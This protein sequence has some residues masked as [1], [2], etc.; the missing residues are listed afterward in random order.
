MTAQKIQKA[1]GLINRHHLLIVFPD[2]NRPQP[3]SLWS[4]LHPKIPMLW[5]WSDEG[6][7][8]VLQMWNL[9]KRLSEDRRVIYLKWYK[10]RATFISQ[11]LFTALLCLSKAHS[12]K[13]SASAK[14]ILS[15]LESDSPL[16]TREVKTLADLRGK[17]NEPEYHRAMKLLFQNFLIVGCGEVDDG[18]FPSLAVGATQNIYEELW[19][20]ASK[21]NVQKAW[22]LV[23]QVMP[24]G[25]DFRKFLDR[26]SEKF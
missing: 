7:D 12:S 20:A 17:D 11:D 5:E 21:M 18:A 15:I 16:S 3:K 13:L 24:K 2:R 10:G 14:E 8:R 23:D 22:S 19:N 25:S 6:D 26:T 4:L 1:V 9:M